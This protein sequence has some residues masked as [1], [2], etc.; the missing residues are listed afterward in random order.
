MRDIFRVLVNG[1]HVFSFDTPSRDAMDF[2]DD[3]P[4][5]DVLREAISL[6]TMTGPWRLTEVE[7]DGPGVHS[8]FHGERLVGRWRVEI[9][10]DQS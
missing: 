3:K 7:D 2:D 6:A 8:V 4:F 9:D 5:A 10:G 1:H